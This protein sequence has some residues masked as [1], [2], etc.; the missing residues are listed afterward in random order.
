MDEWT[1][2]T[3]RKKEAYVLDGGIFC[4]SETHEAF[5]NDFGR[6]D[7]AKEVS[8][9]WAWAKAQGKP[10]CV[11]TVLITNSNPVS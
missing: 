6:G 8:R 10:L 5:I 11:L 9:V 4:M 2:Q 7:C 1:V 3:D